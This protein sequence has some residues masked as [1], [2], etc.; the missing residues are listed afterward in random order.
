MPDEHFFHGLRESAIP[1]YRDDCRVS[2]FCRGGYSA[3]AP[4]P[5]PLVPKLC[6]GTHLS[7]KLRF[8]AVRSPGRRKQSFRDI[9]IP[10]LELGNEE[11]YGETVASD[12]DALQLWRDHLKIPGFLAS[13]FSRFIGT[14]GHLRIRTR[15]RK[16]AFA[17][18]AV[19]I[20]PDGASRCGLA[21]FRL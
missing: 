3:C 19:T 8:V 17:E 1:D 9:C 5:A 21:Y 10:K 11:K 4:R 2:R 6:L 16:R 14:T 12:T 7:W 20:S 18:L 15:R 13:R